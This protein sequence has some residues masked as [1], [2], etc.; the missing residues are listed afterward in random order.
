MKLIEIIIPFA[1]YTTFCQGLKTKDAMFTVL[2][3]NE[4]PEKKKRFINELIVD[5]RRANMLTSSF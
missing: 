4:V 5:E 3:R 2:M 1:V